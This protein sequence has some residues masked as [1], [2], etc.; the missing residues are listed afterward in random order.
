MRTSTIERRIRGIRRWS[1]HLLIKV[2][3]QIRLRS[4]TSR[5]LIAQFPTH[6][7]KLCKCKDL[8][9]ES[10]QYHFP[11]KS[12]SFSDIVQALSQ[13]YQLRSK[14]TLRLISMLTSDNSTTNCQLS[15]S[16]RSQICSLSPYPYE[17]GPTSINMKIWHQTAKI[18]KLQMPSQLHL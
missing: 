18:C 7:A 17:Q 15:S 8:Y 12:S 14:T 11:I 16:V 2:Y 13:I 4:P 9:P 1:R 10:M 5:K 6:R 3:I